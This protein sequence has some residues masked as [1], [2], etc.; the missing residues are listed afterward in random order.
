MSKQDPA[1]PEQAH[2]GL[3]ALI[4]KHPWVPYVAPFA[5]FILL[6]ELQRHI[7]DGVVWLYPLKTALTIGLLIVLRPWLKAFGRWAFP[8]ATAAGLVILGLWLIDYPLQPEAEDPFNPLVRFSG[9]TAY[10][11]IA[12]RILGAAVIVPIIEEFFWRGFIIRWLVDQDFQKVEPGT[13]TWFSFA[14][15]SALFAVEHSLWVAGLIA[16][17]GYNLLYYHTRS[18]RACIIAHA[19]TNLG[20]AIYV[21]VT[22]DWAFW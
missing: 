18:L 11:W 7:T 10:A 1:A 9:A 15:S 12:V 3:A 17:I 22:G 5:V 6:T 4:A 2:T 14:A 8:L 20:L 16:G 19:V 13:F 21:L